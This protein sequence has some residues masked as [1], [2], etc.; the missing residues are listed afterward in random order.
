MISL[1][2]ITIPTPQP[3]DKN[4]SNRQR[5][6]YYY[7]LNQILA[8]AKAANDND[9]FGLLAAIE[10]SASTVETGQPVCVDVEDLS[11]KIFGTAAIIES[12]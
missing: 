1:S 7:V 9:P 6:N 5:E 3:Y 10:G 2:G 4:D 8:A 12:I 11:V